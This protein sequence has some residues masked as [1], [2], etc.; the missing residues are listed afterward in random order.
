MSIC[1]HSGLGEAMLAKSVCYDIKWVTQDRYI[2]LQTQ[3][4]ETCQSSTSKKKT[5]I[6]VSNQ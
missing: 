5:K 1:K 3:C 2:W 6:F 4:L